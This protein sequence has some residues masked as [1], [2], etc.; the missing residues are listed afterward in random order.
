M[1]FPGFPAPFVGW[2]GQQVWASTAQLPAVFQERQEFTEDTLLRWLCDF[3]DVPE[4]GTGC[5]EHVCATSL[6]LFGKGILS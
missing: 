2:R 3:G 4:D 1:R 5:F 6:V